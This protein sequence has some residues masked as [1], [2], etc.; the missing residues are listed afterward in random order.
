MRA[1]LALW[2]AVSLCSCSHESSP[3]PASTAAEDP[4]RP[5][6]LSTTQPEAPGKVPGSSSGA[7]D[8]ATAATTQQE[9][10]DTPAAAAP[11]S[12]EASLE[13]VAALPPAGQLPRGPWIAGKN[14]EV[15]SPA[16]P[17]DVPAG[18]VEVI[19]M[20]WY[21]CPHCYALDATVEA[22]R[23]NK[24]AYI[25]FRRVPVTWGEEHRAHAR[26]L[27]TLQALGKLDALHARVFEEIQQKGDLLF[28][29]SDDQ[30][31]FQKQLAF[32]KANGISESDFTTAYNGMGVQLKVQQADD[33]VHR[34]RI[35]TVPTFV[36]NGKYVTDVGMAGDPAKLTRLIDD[37]AASETHH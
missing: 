37:L 32:A 33:L 36:I 2:L 4:T 13:R 21:A 15:L 1:L 27:Y 31:T 5:S 25:D 22:W 7:V 8:L 19:E 18:K 35:D 23:K 12:T 29:P 9:G 3:S 10:A 20:F 30:G 28:V 34:E 17:T 11:D 6:N 14:Y 16:Q 24:P 26:L